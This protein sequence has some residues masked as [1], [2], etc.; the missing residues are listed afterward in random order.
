MRL[1]LLLALLCPYS[2]S[3]VAASQDTNLPPA[4]DPNPPP[5]FAGVWVERN[6]ASGPAMRIK[7]TPQGSQLA[8]YLSYMAS[9]DSRP[10]AVATIHNDTA[11]FTV[12]EACAKMYQSPGYSY[13]NPGESVWSFRLEQ[14]TDDPAHG[15]RLF[16]THET[17]WYA[18][19]DGHPIGTE[20]SVKVLERGTAVS[21]QD[22]DSFQITSAWPP[23]DTKLREAPV[24]FH[25]RIRYTLTSMDTAVLSIGSER[26]WGTSQ[27]CHD[28]VAQHHTEGGTTTLLKKGTGETDVAFTWVG[29]VPSYS[30]V[31][32]DV[33]TFV[34]L[35]GRFWPEENGLPVPPAQP[36][37]LSSHCYSVLPAVQGTNLPPAGKSNADSSQLATLLIGSWLDQ[38]Q[39]GLTQV[40][41]RR[42]GERILVHYWMTCIPSD[43]DWGEE[44]VEL[45]DGMGMV[46]WEHGS[47]TTKMQLIPQPDGPLRV[48]IRAEY[49]VHSSRTDK[50]YA[51]FFKRQ[52]AQQDDAPA[53]A[54]RALLRQVVEQF[55]TLPVY[56]ESESTEI[57]KTGQ[58]ETRQVNNAPEEVLSPARQDARRDRRWAGAVC[59]AGG[60]EIDVEDLYRC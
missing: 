42:D 14:T 45:R 4:G 34:G 5:E 60:W 23:I 50:G 41:V 56:Y 31:P 21:A 22:G 6:P 58:T 44:A 38:N 17:R 25:A 47:Q 3:L 46:V 32:K 37:Y 53:A 19:C 36:Y 57:L 10:F 59:R 43:C 33:T 9:W 7:L 40:N 39:F 12:R 11:T 35:G 48:T 27:G 26:F 13:D 51:E 8:V 16:H 52:V 29:D 28:P 20:R 49:H 15:P 55:R 30:T 54:A 2:S 18:P 1:F 24:E